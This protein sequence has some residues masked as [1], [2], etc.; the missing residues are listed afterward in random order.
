M[1]VAE[2]IYY[3]IYFA[4]VL[5]GAIAVVLGLG[6]SVHMERRWGTL[7]APAIPFLITIGITTGSLLSGRNLKL[8]G[9]DVDYAT[10]GGDGRAASVWGLRM[11]TISILTICFARIIGQILQRTPRDSTAGKPLFLAF[12]AFF[13]A[14]NLLNSAL[15]TEPAFVHG[16]FYPIVA[17]TALYIARREPPTT[18]IHLARIGLFLMMVLSLLVA[19]IAP[20]LAVQTGYKGWLPG[21]DIRL[22]GVGSNANS[23]GPL[24]LVYLLL[25]YMQPGQLR[26]LRWTGIFCAS[27]VL[28]LA[29]SK[30][31]WLAVVTTGSLLL[32]HRYG[33]TPRGHI[34]PV[35]ILIML[36]LATTLLLSLLIFDPARLMDRL[37]MSDAGSDVLTLTGR[38]RIWEIALMEWERSPL[39][40]YGPEIWEQAFRARIGMS[41][42][43]SAHNQF[44]Q[45][46]SAAGLFGFIT[47]II[48][49]WML[50]R[51][52][53]QAAPFTKGVS[54]ALFVV[55]LLRCITETPLTLGTMLNG[56][57]L[58]QLILFQ[59]ALVYS[60]HQP[61]PVPEKTEKNH[62]ANP[63]GPDSLHTAWQRHA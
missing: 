55:I 5:A 22:W 8:A 13:V 63:A 3:G 62:P 20:D 60:Q 37:L 38:F 18:F 27:V 51:Y 41:Y 21:L 25:E 39:F 44:L 26:L 48:Y 47:L 23:I 42:A 52:A 12:V 40:G 14:N 33:R 31:A 49:L 54:T 61:A 1:S 19:V 43:F 53:I 6:L 9:F 2:F 59:I 34:K 56:D 16:L 4:V 32:W 50:G 17:V 35:F 45:A 24:A 58:T 28:V 57:F 10:S 29:Q 11:I 15:G 46:L 36:S 30:T 7:F